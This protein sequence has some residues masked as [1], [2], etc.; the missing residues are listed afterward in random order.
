MYS[1][2]WN[3]VR[4]QEGRVQGHATKVWYVR[5]PRLAPCKLLSL[6]RGLRVLEW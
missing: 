2:N 1:V 6:L 5:R 3:A 4:H